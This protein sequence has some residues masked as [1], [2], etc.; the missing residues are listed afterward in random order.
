MGENPK[1]LK[2]VW[3]TLIG[4][5]QSVLGLFPISWAQ[6]IKSES[7]LQLSLA[8]F[9]LARSHERKAEV[10]TKLGRIRSFLDAFL[11]Q[12]DRAGIIS[13]LVHYPGQGVGNFG[14]LGL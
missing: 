7:C 3:R 1:L 13:F 2:N 4:L 6:L 14:N 12:R 5:G 10:V 8:G 9:L 11:K